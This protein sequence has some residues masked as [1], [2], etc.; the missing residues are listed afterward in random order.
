[1]ALYH[2]FEQVRLRLIGKVRFTDNPDDE[3]R[4][5][6]SLAK[7]LMDEA[8]GTVEL[9]LSPRYAAPFQTDAGGAFACLPMRPTQEVV[10]TLCEIQSVLRILGT[11]FG[12]G[13]TTDSEKYSESLQ[14][15]YDKQL[16]RLT[17]TKEESYNDFIY[18][19]LPGLRLNWG[20]AA[21]DDGFAGMVI[22]TSGRRSD[23]SFAADQVN[24]PAATFWNPSGEEFCVY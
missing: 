10:R 17:K 20:N 4:M 9:D 1:M 11:D 21:A 6:I 22:N 12:R 16:E 13:S 19:P 23:G 18:P 3:N 24:D 5:P 14:K 7:I 2:R 8:E 15:L